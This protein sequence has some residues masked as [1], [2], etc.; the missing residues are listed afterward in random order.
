MS[1]TP[2]TTDDWDRAVLDFWFEEL[3]SEQWFKKDDAVDRAIVDRFGATYEA[4]RGM[5]T[6]TLLATPERA[7]AA[8]IVL[9]QFPRNMFRD[10]PRTFESDARALELA[11]KTLAAGLDRG[12]DRD[13]RHFMCM[14]FMHSE[15]LAD[16]DRAIGLFEAIGNEDGVK[17]A[18]LHRDVI[19]KFGRFPHRNAVL[20][21]ETTPE[22]Q[23]HLDAHGGF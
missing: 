11:D 14:P 10:D 18:K 7:L 4:V 3:A 17:Y 9:D 15:T 2:P 5:D 8:V 22:E 20:G 16:Q 21:R 19:V 23:A 13:Q 12:M 1:T 6:G